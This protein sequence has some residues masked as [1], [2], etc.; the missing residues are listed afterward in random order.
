MEAIRGID[1]IN[2][3]FVNPAVTIGNFDG[4]HLGHQLLFKKVKEQAEA[5]GGESVVITFDP[6]P[7]SVLRPQIGLKL[8]SKC[9]KKLELIEKA[10][11]DVLICIKF[12]RDFANTTAEEFVD[13][14]LWEKIGVKNLMVGYD[15]SFGRN[16]QGNI[17]F[18][19]EKG[20]QLGFSVT[21]VEPLYV[22]D[23]IVSSTKVR[24]LIV[25]G[26]MVQVR[27]LLGRPYQMTGKVLVGKRRGG[28][29]L[30]FPTAN[31][32]LAEDEL[33]P[34]LGVYATQVIYKGKSHDG[35]MNI[36]YNPTF[37]DEHISAEVHVFDFS[38]DI[39]GQEIEVNL[40]ERL[41]DEKKF[42]N[43][44]ELI[45][46]IKKDIEK[47]NEI[48]KQDSFVRLGFCM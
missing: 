39:Y 4:V 27:R 11:V 19:R 5:T 48:L 38:E 37:G 24:E 18:L 20:R 14:I 17:E 29:V 33:C 2:R 45:A 8:I 28:P 6:H 47:A 16:R 9:S 13:D 3:R 25:A 21:V 22:D 34:G 35:V 31:I 42:A 15:Y 43:P 40:I 36:G 23:I 10:G 41:R 26:D 7:V 44:E 32:E 12:T 46:Q 30:G 1:N